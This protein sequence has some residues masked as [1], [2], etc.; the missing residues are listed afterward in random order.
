MRAA[1][2]PEG[3][4]H[5]AHYRAETVLLGSHDLVDELA[6]TIRVGSDQRLLAHIRRELVLCHVVHLTGQLRDYHRP[7]LR[8]PMLQDELHDVVLCQ[9]R[10]STA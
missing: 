4:L 8:L 6:T 2:T 1:L 3:I 10:I 7:V 9:R 5:E